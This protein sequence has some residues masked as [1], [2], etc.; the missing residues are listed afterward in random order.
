MSYAISFE[1]RGVYT[2]DGKSQLTSAEVDAYNKKIEAA[3][4]E[5]W[6]AKPDHWQVYVDKTNV[7][8]TWLGTALGTILERNTFRGNIARNMT[9]IRFRGTNGAV[10]YGRFGSDWSMLCR[11][12]KAK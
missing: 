2:P 3:E 9:S 7:V 1:D 10:Y 6:A 11:V 4:L 12:R 8:R 5:H